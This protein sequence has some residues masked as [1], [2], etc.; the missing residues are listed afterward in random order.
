MCLERWHFWL[1]L[2]DELAS[3][4][5]AMSDAIRRAVSKAAQTMRTIEGQGEARRPT[6]GSA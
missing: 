1:G 5:C 4:E 2:L 6:N 3:E